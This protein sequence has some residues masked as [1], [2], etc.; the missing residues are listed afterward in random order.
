[1]VIPVANKYPPAKVSML[2]RDPLGFF[3]PWPSL[4]LE[5]DISKQSWTKILLEIDDP[6]CVFPHLPQMLL[7]PDP[8]DSRY[9][10]HRGLSHTFT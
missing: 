10:S 7:S 9:I 4:D 6:S 3:K 2:G 1:M 8:W 5:P